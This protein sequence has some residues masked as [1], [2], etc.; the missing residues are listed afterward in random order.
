MTYL[1][2]G[3]ISI[4]GHSLDPYSQGESWCTH[5]EALMDICPSELAVLLISVLEQLTGF[6]VFWF[7]NTSAIARRKTATGECDGRAWQR[8]ELG[9]HLLSYGVP[10]A[11]SEKREKATP[12]L[13]FLIC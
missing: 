1:T 10:C 4:Y 2:S 9:L 6:N 8:H 3:D 7:C 5:F 13:V 11:S 12:S